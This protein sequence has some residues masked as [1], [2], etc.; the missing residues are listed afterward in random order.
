M[1]QY[2]L[3]FPEMTNFPSIPK[4]LVYFL[5]GI[6]IPL[7][8]PSK[9][10]H[11]NSIVSF[12]ENQQ[13]LDFLKLSQKIAVLICLHFEIFNFWLNRYGQCSLCHSST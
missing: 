12:L 8:F 5:H 3:K 9:N 6:P 11:S 10:S 2:F 7:A 13:F 4:S 1:E